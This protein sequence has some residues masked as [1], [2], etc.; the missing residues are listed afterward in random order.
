MTTD[1][2]AVLNAGSSSLKFS[3]FTAR[4]FRHLFHGQIEGIGTAPRLKVANVRGEV[5]LDQRWS[6]DEGFD[7]EAALAHLLRATSISSVS[8]RQ[9]KQRARVL[10]IRATAFWRKMRP[11][12]RL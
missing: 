5:L 7:H 9:R 10:Y 11:L 8:S 6:G 1:A 2:I 4:I 12:R 3:V